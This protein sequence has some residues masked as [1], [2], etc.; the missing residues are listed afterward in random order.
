LVDENIPC[1]WMITVCRKNISELR[2][3]VESAMQVG[4]H[5]FIT[6]PL[7][8]IGRGE[9]DDDNKL[10]NEEYLQLLKFTMDSPLVYG[11]RIRFGWGSDLGMDTWWDEYVLSPLVR[12][13][14]EEEFKNML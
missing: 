4:C 9:D 11:D 6:G 10:N 7:S 14:T 2:N 3:C 1:A 12:E 13:P 5:G 8:A